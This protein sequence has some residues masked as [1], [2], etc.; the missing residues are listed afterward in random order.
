MNEWKILTAEELMERRDLLKSMSNEAR[1]LF[2]NTLRA[3]HRLEL[4]IQLLRRF[5][6]NQATFRDKHNPLCGVLVDK[7]C[8]CEWEKVLCESSKGDGD[9]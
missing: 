6:A 4:Q 1:L 3:A 5:I 2:I 9:E 7:P 8:N